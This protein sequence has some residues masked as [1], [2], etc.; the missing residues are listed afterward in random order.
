VK[1][2]HREGADVHTLPHTVHGLKETDEG[3]PWGKG[4]CWVVKEAHGEGAD[5]YTLPRT[6]HGPKETNDSGGKHVVVVGW[7]VTQVDG[8]PNSRMLLTL[9]GI[10][11]L[12]KYCRLVIQHTIIVQRNH[13]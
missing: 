6:V 7:S 9:H 2:A 1:E 5:I 3:Q 12:A 13:P 10:D 8:A 4:G 11:L